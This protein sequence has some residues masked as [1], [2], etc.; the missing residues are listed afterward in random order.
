[1]EDRDRKFRILV[2]DPEGEVEQLVRNLLAGMDCDVFGVQSNEPAYDTFV[3]RRPFHVVVMNLTSK[4][5]RLLDMIPVLQ[6]LHPNTETLLMSRSADERMWADVLA[7]GGYDLLTVP[8][9]RQELV[10]A[11][12]RAL[13]REQS[14]EVLHSADAA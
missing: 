5:M 14:A 10:N 3:Y 9:D 13:D 1:M 11:L 4:T 8:P 2:I 7:F 12:R 6:Q